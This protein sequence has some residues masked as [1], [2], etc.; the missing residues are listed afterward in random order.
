MMAISLSRIRQCR[1]RTSWRGDNIKEDQKNIQFQME[2][3][4]VRCLQHK[5]CQQSAVRCCQQ[6]VVRSRD[7]TVFLKKT[8]SGAKLM[9][10]YVTIPA[11]KLEY[12]VIYIQHI[13]KPPARESSHLLMRLTV[14]RFKSAEQFN[15]IFLF[16]VG[17][18]CILIQA[19]CFCYVSSCSRVHRGARQDED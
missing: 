10:Y 17:K 11:S 6:S 14:S 18:T 3:S 19:R 5:F 9:K 13:N 1:S 12:Y 8:K 16:C 2:N 7:I 15:I 4:A